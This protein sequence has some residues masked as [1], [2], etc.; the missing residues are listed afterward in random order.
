MPTDEKNLRAIGVTT[1][2]EVAGD[3]R[4]DQVV[5]R[6]N[7]PKFDKSIQLEKEELLTIVA[8]STWP[9]DEDILLNGLSPLIRQQ[10]LNLILAPHEPSLEHF[11]KLNKNFKGITFNLLS[12][13]KETLVNLKPGE[14]LYIDRVGV[15]ADIYSRGDL[16]FVGGSFKSKVHSVMEPLAHGTITVVGPFIENN[17]EAQIFQKVYTEMGPAV[18]VVKTKEQLL[19][20]VKDLMKK[21]TSMASAQ[22]KIISEVQK[23]AGA[24]DSAIQHLVHSWYK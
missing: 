22:M 1:K 14:V 21:R 9:E 12:D 5:Y 19:N 7:H 4:F 8:G 16:S 6:S 10:E 2:I 23:R 17:R 24:V 11:K 20:K 18:Q 13:F 15:L 3:T